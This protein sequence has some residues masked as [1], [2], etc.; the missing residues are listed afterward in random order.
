MEKRYQ[1]FVSSTYTD[2]IE[3]RQKVFQT[4]MEM[5][6]IPAGMEL[7]SAAD[8]DQFDFIK[9]VIDDCDYYLLMIGGRYGSLAEDQISFTEKE[10]DYAI[11]L[12]MKVVVLVHKNPD[13]IPTGKTDQDAELK[14]KLGAFK[15]KAMTGRM[16]DFWEDA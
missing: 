4:L 7:F 1:V 16:V 13:A 11:S 12:E 8:E 2:L 6:C 5:G 10:F 14:E 15:Q 9:K 3:E